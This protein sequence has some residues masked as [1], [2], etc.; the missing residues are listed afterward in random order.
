MLKFIVT[1][2]T[3]VMDTDKHSW[4]PVIRIWGR[5]KEG[6][7][8]C[9]KIRDFMPYFYF[10]YHN[11]DV[12]S[13]L[14]KISEKCNKSNN[15]PPNG[16]F[17]KNLEVVQRTTLMGYQPNG[18][19][20]VYKMTLTAPTQVTTA[21]NIFAAQN[22]CT[23]EANVLFVMRFMIDTGFGGCHWLVF[24]NVSNTTKRETICP[25]EYD[26]YTHSFRVD[27]EDQDL[28]HIR[29]LSF[30]IEACK[31]SGPGFVD[32]T[33]DDPITQ[34]G[35]SVTT[36]KG[37]NIDDVVFCMVEGDQHVAAL[38]DPNV[39]VVECKGE[40]NLL[41]A[42]S[43]FIHECQADIITGYN[44]D[45]F[46]FPYTFDRAKYLELRDTFY[47]FTLE[48]KRNAMLRK[49]FFNSK[50]TGARE[51]WELS[52]EGRFAMDAIKFVKTYF[53]LR[54]YGLGFV[55]NHFL[56]ESK[57][58]MPYKLIPAYQM[59]TDE[60][61]AHLAH[62]CHKDARLVVD[63]LDKRK[64][65]VM[66]MQN[67]R[68]CMVP[69][70]FLVQKG[71]QERSYSLLARACKRRGFIIPSSPND[72]SDIKTQGA[73]VISPLVGLYL[74]P[75]V[76]LDFRSLYP[77]IM[78]CWNLCYSTKVSRKWAQ[79]HLKPGDYYE[80]PFLNA[81]YVFVADHIHKGFLLEIESTLF[82]H[83]NESKAKKKAAAGT[84]DEIVYDKLQEADKLSMNALYGFT[85]ANKVCDKDVME[86]V[87]AFGRWMLE[88]TKEIVESTFEGSKVV[89]GDSVTATTPVLIRYS[90]NY[91]T[92]IN[93]EDMPLEGEWLSVGEK[94]YG[95]PRRN[96]QVWSDK[97]FTNVKW[98]IRH[99][100]KKRIFRVLTH[101]GCVC[102]T[103][104]HSLL[105]TSAKKVSPKD[106]SV[107]QQ[108]LHTPLPLRPNKVL[109]RKRPFY[110]MGL[111]YGD[112]SCGI[113]DTASGTKSSWAINNQNLDYLTY[114]KFELE[115]FYRN[116]FTFKIL[117]TMKSSS[118]YKLVVTGKH[119]RTF[120]EIWRNH[121]YTSRK[122]K[123]V[124][125]FMFNEATEFVDIFL[126]GYYCADGDKDLHGYHR[127]DNK[128]EI[129]TA[130]LLLLYERMGYKTS[131]NNRKDK[132]D[133]YRITCTKLTQRKDERTIKRI[134]E[135]P[136]QNDY[137]YDLETENHHFA[138]GV[139]HMVV[140]NTDSVFVT[141]G[142]VSVDEA[143][144]LG[145]QAADKVTAFLSKMRTDQ[146]KEPV[147]LLQREKVFLPF[148]LVSKKKYA[149]RKSLGP[150]MPFFFSS[151]GLETVRRDNAKIGSGTLQH[152][153][154]EIIMNG[155]YD[156]SRSIA[157]VH[158][159]VEKLKTGQIEFSELI[160]SKSLSKSAK[161]YAESKTK[162]VHSELARRIAER[163][164]IT[165]EQVYHTG[166]RVKFVMVQGTKNSK[167]FERSED[168]LFA[169]KN[170]TPID[171]DYYIWNQMMKP[172][173]RIFTP[174][175]AP[176]EKLKKINSKGDS[177][178]IN[179]K[180]IMQ[181][182]AY[183]RL[184]VGPHMNRV[185]QRV[186][187]ADKAVPGSIMSFVKKQKRC[188]GCS[189][190]FMGNGAVCKHCD[191]KSEDIKAQLNQKMDVLREKQDQCLAT[192]RACV[193]DPDAIDIPCSNNDCDNY[194][195]REKVVVD[196]E[197]LASK[198]LR[199]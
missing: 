56:G 8:V 25:L 3:Y 11:F 65:T 67:A 44:I 105:D 27:Y 92:Y 68:V 84:D 119:V 148:L 31:F 171:F 63:I 12:Q 98:V 78:M 150:G 97:G 73:I 159:T 69:M 191:G 59:G 19:Q 114:A 24:D 126:Q 124:P 157:Y 161:H 30:D 18:A 149:G 87:T 134:E 104:D 88:K 129:G 45:G 183:K 15:C 180:E 99:K 193:N 2:V 164:H 172:L 169:L 74:I 61:R 7:H 173:L 29:R 154:D 91:M 118:V 28:G 33:E 147:H 137:V 131:I 4:G 146:G 62:Y 70:K 143:L 82:A 106:V 49:A 158:E 57:V 141:F 198:L 160:I 95:M 40:A 100:T 153:L 38:P 156:G 54:S 170:R 182:T 121:F 138:A 83:R 103:E 53:K 102:V 108:L 140:H 13:F 26:A 64:A 199:F 188:L 111:F 89:Y 50:A 132:L 101:T 42:F 186:V 142:D 112:G 120:V 194:Y 128:G 76:T 1:D 179:D 17:I 20:N 110:S 184:F 48:T 175:L 85:G 37:E 192:C 75:V 181:T 177:V 47:Q 115:Y 163:S 133:V 168:P 16:Q 23:Y 36:V 41:Y 197:D 117:D 32:A 79:A 80:V 5:T 166:D 152:C 96:I 66:Y 145:Q 109:F 43:E 125:S 122:Q 6:R 60:Q 195:R 136:P 22:L 81:S 190:G 189:C 130:G 10:E 127:F 113:Y 51:D 135:M 107:G 39:R 167:A 86:S 71:Q 77:S 116:Q 34:I 174:I 151:S 123:C 162:A 165:G 93:I 155:D 46:D 35:C 178:Y 94:Q 176:H 21:R 14:A 139:G 9:V 185:V 196:I 72:Q 144:D 58:D 187:D 52:V 90:N 55:S